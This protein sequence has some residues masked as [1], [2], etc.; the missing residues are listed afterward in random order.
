ME[1][2]KMI[3]YTVFYPFKKDSHFDF[4]YYQN[5]H[6]KILKSYAGD[7]CKG[8][9][10]LK[11]DN[12]NDEEPAF[13][14]ICHIFFNTEE[15]FLKIMGKAKIELKADVKNYTDIVPYSRVFEI[16]MQE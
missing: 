15:E 6:L 9:I 4:D 3:T 8:I 12:S 10:V 5:K 7:A 13:T 16:S 2:I 14:C 11:G 1:Q